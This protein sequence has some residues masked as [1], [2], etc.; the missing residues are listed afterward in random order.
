MHLALSTVSRFQHNSIAQRRLS[1]HTSMKRSA[2]SCE[3]DGRGDGG[4]GAGARRGGARHAARLRHRRRRLG[5]R[6]GGAQLQEGHRRADLNRYEARSVPFILIRQSV[7][8]R[9][10]KQDVQCNFAGEL[11]ALVDTLESPTDDWVNKII[12]FMDDYSV[13]QHERIENVAERIN[14]KM[15][16]ARQQIIDEMSKENL[17]T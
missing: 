13:R 8:Q 15:S 17:G 16:E 2:H 1:K 6:A 12:Q 11:A 9:C 14:Q 4:V 3:R 7:Q 5:L 10:E